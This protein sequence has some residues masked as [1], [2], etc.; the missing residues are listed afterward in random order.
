MLW[1]TKGGS[2]PFLRDINDKDPAAKL[3]DSHN[4]ACYYS[5]VNGHP[6]WRQ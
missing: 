6:T 5:F 1:A 3:D 4:K 2:W